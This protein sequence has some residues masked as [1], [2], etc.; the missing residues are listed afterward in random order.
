M[1]QRLVFAVNLE[2]F[3]DELWYVFQPTHRKWFASVFQI[4][5]KMG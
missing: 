3:A 4:K 2:M 5:A 1:D